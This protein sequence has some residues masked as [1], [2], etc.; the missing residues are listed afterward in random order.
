M[1]FIVTFVA[2]L[3]VCGIRATLCFCHDFRQGILWNK[4]FVTLNTYIHN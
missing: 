1:E 4:D 3:L 2:V